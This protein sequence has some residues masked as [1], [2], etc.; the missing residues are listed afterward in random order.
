MS[1]DPETRAA[2]YARVREMNHL[3]VNQNLKY[4]TSI[5][6]RPYIRVNIET[7]AKELIWKENQR[8]EKKAV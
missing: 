4:K 3:Y 1:A 2:Y 6:K 8:G 7:E 5:E